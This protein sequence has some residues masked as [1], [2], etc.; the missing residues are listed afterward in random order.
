LDRLTVFV[1]FSR[2]EVRLL[3]GI[4]CAIPNTYNSQFLINFF[5]KMFLN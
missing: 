4:G 2:F 5:Q 1:V 3:A